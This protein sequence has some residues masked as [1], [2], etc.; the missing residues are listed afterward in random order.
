M[1]LRRTSQPARGIVVSGSA[2]QNGCSCN[3]AQSHRARSLMETE[4][5]GR[6]W[7]RPAKLT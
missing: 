3:D 2:E 1:L 4:S 6:L 7:T 5:A